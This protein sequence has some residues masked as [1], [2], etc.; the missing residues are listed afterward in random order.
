MV[1]EKRRLCGA[2]RP[3]RSLPQADFPVLAPTTNLIAAMPTSEVKRHE[4]ILL[5]MSIGLYGAARLCQLVADHLP[6]LL[7][8]ALH[9]VPPA[10]FAVVHGRALYRTKGFVVFA[11]S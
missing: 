4:D 6:I 3:S 10:I 8:V 1:L 2:T 11:A 7:T 9:V 5:R